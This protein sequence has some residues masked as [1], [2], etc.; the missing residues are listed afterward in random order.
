MFVEGTMGR[1][2]VH[3]EKYD[4]KDSSAISQHTTVL[5]LD[6]MDF[7]YNGPFSLDF[8]LVITSIYC[9]GLFG[10]L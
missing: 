9:T 5:N 4:A 8:S 3:R 7:E 1:R 10:A 6:R 2:C